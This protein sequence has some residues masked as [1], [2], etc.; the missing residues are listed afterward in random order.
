MKAQG[1]FIESISRANFADG[2]GEHMLVQLENDA[3]YSSVIPIKMNSVWDYQDMGELSFSLPGINENFIAKANMPKRFSEEDFSWSGEI[4]NEENQII[5]DVVFIREGCKTFGR[6]NFSSRSFTIR[7]LNLSCANDQVLMEIDRTT[8]SDGCGIIMADPEVI[9]H[10]NSVSETPPGPEEECDAVITILVLYTPEVEYNYNNEAGPDPHQLAQEGIKDL[11]K[12]LSESNIP[13]TNVAALLVG[14]ERWNVY[15]EISDGRKAVRNLAESIAA[16]PRLRDSLN[17]DLVLLFQAKDLTAYNQASG[18][19]VDIA[20]IAS[21]INEVNNVDDTLNYNNAFSVIEATA[22]S[23]TFVHEVG[24]LLGC[25]HL[26]GNDPHQYA[27]ARIFCTS[28]LT[29][30]GQTYCAA[31][32]KKSTIMNGDADSIEVAPRI[33]RF[34][35]PEGYYNGQVTGSAV[36][37]NARAIS[38]SACKVSLFGGRVE[39]DFQDPPF[40]AFVSGPTDVYH[41]TEGSYS[42]S[43]YYWGCSDGEVSYCWEISW[44]YGENYSPLSEEEDAVLNRSDVHPFMPV[45]YIRLTAICSE[46][47]D[48]SI[49]FIELK[50]WSAHYLVGA[51]DKTPAFE[52]Q[53][54]SLIK[55]DVISPQDAE[56]S[57]L[58]HKDNLV[59]PNPTSD[60]FYLNVD[61]QTTTSSGVSLLS[62]QGVSYNL[63]SLGKSYNVSHIPTGFY[64]AIIEGKDKKLYSPILIVR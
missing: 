34:S 22:D 63:S 25:R 20:G 53:A 43:S 27:N 5:G 59:Y 62:A 50:N 1:G 51:T 39:G 17:A 19:I 60:H 8:V 3:H 32:A 4:F 24:H 58:H 64:I 49:S 61:A 36:H 6:I 7:D 45:G 54:S 46:E 31:G 10:S 14:V 38:L 41:D 21:G 16:A 12:A 57:T 2:Q 40:N 52:T 56:I 37:N 42:Y 44:D 18:E 48:T 29:I 30:Q 26:K 11:N 33:F 15:S 35:N 55:G 23:E 47:P 9:D 13:N 28:P